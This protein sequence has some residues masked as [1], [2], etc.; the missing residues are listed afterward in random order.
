[1]KDPV[2]IPAID[3]LGGRCVRLRQGDYEQATV[4]SE[5]PTEVAVGFAEAGAQHIHVVDLDAAR[6]SGD[7]KAVIRAILR[8]VDLKVLV[9]GGVRT[10]DAAG[11]LIKAGAHGVVMGTTAV[12]DPQLLEKCATKHPGRLV[13]ALDIRDN[14]PAVQGWTETE[15]VMIGDLVG[16]WDAL[17]LGG[18][19]LTCIDRD[20]TM[21][22]PDLESLAMVRRMTTHFLHYS[23]GVTS[24]EDINRVAAAG[25]HA[26]ILGRAL[27]EG[28]LTLA[29]ALRR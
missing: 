7:N 15:P 1:L 27:Y 13:A 14:V 23:G 22:G 2:V 20:G 6:G 26:V 18:V 19:I 3:I 16:R 9:A 11:A 28:R 8:R 29:Q 12:R 21:S 17:P 10:A 5:D 24:R 4:Y 25:A